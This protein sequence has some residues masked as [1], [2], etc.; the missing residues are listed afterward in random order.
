MKEQIEICEFKNIDIAFMEHLMNAVNK[1]IKENY[2]GYKAM[3]GQAE[4]GDN[5]RLF[6][7]P[8]A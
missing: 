1:Y 2:P 5:M 7:I 4:V 3:M 8:K 6:L